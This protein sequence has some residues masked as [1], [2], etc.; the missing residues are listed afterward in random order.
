MEYRGVAA[1]KGY[2]GKGSRMEFIVD[3]LDIWNCCM[4]TVSSRLIRVIM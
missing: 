2:N 3:D 1:R 4:D